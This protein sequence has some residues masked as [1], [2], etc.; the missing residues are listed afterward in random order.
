MVHKNFI[1]ALLPIVAV[2]TL[3][4]SACIRDNKG[5]APTTKDED[6]VKEKSCVFVFAA[7]SLHC[8][9]SLMIGEDSVKVAG[10]VIDGAYPS[11]AYSPLGDSARVW[12]ADQ[13]SHGGYSNGNAQFTYDID[14]LDNWRTLVTVACR[15][16]MDSA[17]A[18]FDR[19]MKEDVSYRSPSFKY[20]YVFSFE[21]TFWTDS[22]LTY[23]FS[24]Y[25]YMGGAHGSSVGKGQTFVASTGKK[26]DADM[27]FMPES[28]SQLI[29]LI[30]NGL[31]K[32][33]FNPGNSGMEIDSLGEALLVL[34]DALPLPV[35][36][37]LCLDSGVVFIYQ[38]YEIASYAEGMPACTLPY[39]VVK[40]LM[41]PEVARLLPE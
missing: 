23:A 8:E 18:D 35:C 38:Q 30:K 19:Y 12:I 11:C 21:P 9:D 32:Q 16:Y 29:D 13:L 36:P 10:I 41:R 7:D 26:L 3:V 4:V 22:I 27:M 17:K 25:A 14:M 40:P 34:S 33:Y 24:S 20:E 28:R 5:G 6:S 1:R 15:A 37:P 31:W 39:K 2:G